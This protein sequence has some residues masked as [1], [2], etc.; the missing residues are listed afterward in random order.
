MTKINLKKKI[1][2]LLRELDSN[3]CYRLCCVLYQRCSNNKTNAC[4]KMEM[5]VMKIIRFFYIFKNQCLISNSTRVQEKANER[6]SHEGPTGLDL[7]LHCLFKKHR[8]GEKQKSKEREFQ[9]EFLSQATCQVVG[10]I[11]ERALLGAW[12]RLHSIAKAQNL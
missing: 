12:G 9:T 7:G 5:N 11:E 3:G 1:I 4:S 2:W 10:R 8:Q 6:S